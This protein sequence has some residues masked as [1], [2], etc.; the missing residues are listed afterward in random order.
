[1]NGCVWVGLAA[2]KTAQPNP[3]MSDMITT[4]MVSRHETVTDYDVTIC[5]LV[6]VFMEFR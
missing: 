5:H 1:M 4:E 6:H 3:N 2:H